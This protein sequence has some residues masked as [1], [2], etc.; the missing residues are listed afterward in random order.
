MFLGFV[1]FTS[2]CLDIASAIEFCAK[3]G[4]LDCII[5]ILHWQ[6]VLAGFCVAGNIFKVD[7]F[8]D[9]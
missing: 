8:F 2:Y 6:H 5:L 1:N 9:G 4:A 7:I 3:Q